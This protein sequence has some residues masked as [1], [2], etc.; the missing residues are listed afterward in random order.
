MYNRCE[1]WTH[2]PLDKV[3]MD[4]YIQRVELNEKEN[5]L[6]R[7]MYANGYEWEEDKK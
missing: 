5:W 4:A 3:Y 1:E 6:W 2:A 7:K